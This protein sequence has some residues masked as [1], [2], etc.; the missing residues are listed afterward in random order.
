MRRRSRLQLWALLAG[1]GL[2]FGLL[3][4]ATVWQ[5]SGPEEMGLH[6]QAF[7]AHPGW[8]RAWRLEADFRACP[9]DECI[10]WSGLQEPDVARMT[11][12]AQAG[13]TDAVRLELILNRMP[14]ERDIGS[15]DTVLCCGPILKARPRRFLQLSREVGLS[16]TQVVTASQLDRDDDYA[17]YDRE[18]RARRA[19][20]ARVAVPA[21]VAWRDRDLAALD[22]A[23]ARNKVRLDSLNA[24]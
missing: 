10:A 24:G 23:L 11:A 8:F 17:G 1:L 6:W 2:G 3:G 22:E 13:Q 20:L 4:F 15:E 12:L 18:L 21:L 14:T 19:A 16:S 9:Q 5:P 7:L